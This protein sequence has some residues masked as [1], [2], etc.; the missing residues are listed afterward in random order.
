MIS[1]LDNT[2]GYKR[3]GEGPS[4]LLLEDIG[5]MELGMSILGIHIYGSDS[6]NILMEGKFLSRSRLVSFLLAY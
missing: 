4:G 3:R 1:S 2:A 6:E 5:C